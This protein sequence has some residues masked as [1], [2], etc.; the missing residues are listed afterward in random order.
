MRRLFAGAGAVLLSACSTVPPIDHNNDA[1]RLEC[2]WDLKYPSVA[3]ADAS[4]GQLREVA[5]RRL[6]A[7]QLTAAWTLEQEGVT[8]E[9]FT[10]SPEDRARLQRL[11]SVVLP[12]LERYPAGFFANVRLKNIVLV[13]ELAVGG[14]RR[15]AMPMAETDGVAYADNG[16]KV[17]CPA[18]M[19]MRVHHEFYHFIDHREYNDYYHADPTWLAMNPEGLQYG[20]GGSTFYGKNLQDLGHVKDGLVSMYSGYG[21]E[22]DKAETFGW[23]MTPDYAA[24]LDLYALA[25]ARLAAKVKYMREQLL[26]YSRPPV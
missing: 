20:K 12:G 16:A 24:R 5:T 9:A 1:L 15:L 6:A 21:Q 26:K 23:M 8:A 13:K 10:D 17:L 3:P 18:G 22:E 4:V 2:H 14:Q 19:E 7:L 11:L 25:D